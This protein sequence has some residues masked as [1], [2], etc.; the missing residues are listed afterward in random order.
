MNME[1]YFLSFLLKSLCLSAIIL[2][3]LMI[4]ALFGRA[5]PAKL[6]YAIWLVV[7]A[8]LII[9]MPFA[10]GKGII[11]VPLSMPIQTQYA[12]TE[13]QDIKTFPVTAPVISNTAAAVSS[14]SDKLISPFMICVFFWGI[15][16]LAV[17]VWHIRR[18]ACFLRTI[19]RWGKI[20]KDENTLSVFKAV[21]EEMGLSEKN[22]NLLV[23]GFVSSSML[24]GFLRPMI[25]LPEK[26]FQT[27]ELELI[28]KHELIHYKRRDLLVK[29]LS[30]IA[31]SIYWFNPFVYWMNGTMQADGE[32]SCDE[33]VLLDCDKENR[34]F[35]AEII[36]GMIGEKNRVA[37]MLSTCFF[38]R[39]KLSIKK[40][41][42]AIMDSTQKIKWP[43]VL[44]LMTVMALTLFSGSVFAFAF[45]EISPVTAPPEEREL[46]LTVDR[47][48]E[49]AL[50][51]AGGG[52][53]E[54]IEFEYINGMLFYD[55]TVRNGRWQ[56]DVK[57]DAETG[58]IVE[59]ERE[60]AV[61]LT[62]AYNTV[63]VSFLRAMEAAVEKVGGGTI[64]EVE[65]EYENG[66]LIYEVKVIYNNRQYEIKIDAVTGTVL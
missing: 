14:F 35:Y 32:S 41:L 8:G 29:L 30:V 52:M 33:E 59:L 64:E 44:V 26:H 66:I 28:F 23:C 48:M 10:T 61:I 25:L 39:G 4:N 58:K 50:A 7:L 55:I 1:Q 16:A 2:A 11:T 12:V 31:I 62:Q 47:S 42:D 65:L 63:R 46:P 24:T 6:R 56:Y 22:I 49:I 60:A 54:E 3:V 20:V 57:I 17:F 21:Q 51:A 18:Y 53:V 45:Q 34:H 38:Y 36:I 15:V 27:D 43:A 40:R 13:N 5:F 19:K 9:P 37:T